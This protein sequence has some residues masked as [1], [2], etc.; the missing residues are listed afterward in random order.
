MRCWAS[1]ASRQRPASAASSRRPRSAARWSRRFWR[2]WRKIVA[3]SS[4]R[5]SRRASWARRRSSAVGESS[6]SAGRRTPPVHRLLSERPSESSE[7]TESD[8]VTGAAIPRSARARRRGPRLARGHPLLFL[9]HPL[10][11]DAVARE[12]QRLEPF[13][14]NRLVAPLAVSKCA[15]V[16]L[17]ERRDHVAQEPAVAVAQLEEELARVRGIGLVAQVLDRVVFRVFAVQSGPADLFG[18]LALFFDE[19]LFEVCK[20]VLAHLGLLPY[21]EGAHSSFQR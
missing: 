7:R 1:R 3:A 11:V 12:R 20:P 13:F 19:L 9:D 4:L 18:Q 16:E 10:A 5:P 15:V 14:G 21:Q 17:L 2:I 8:N 6:A